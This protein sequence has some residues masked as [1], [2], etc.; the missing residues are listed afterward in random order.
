MAIR[1][2]DSGLPETPD[3]I[4]EGPSVEP[5]VGR[6]LLGARADGAPED[7]YVDEAIWPRVLTSIDGALASDA[8]VVAPPIGRV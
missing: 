7:L 8:D 6:V 2:L 4:C 1:G 5:H 3:G